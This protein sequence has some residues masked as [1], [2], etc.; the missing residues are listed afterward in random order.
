[1][2][3]FRLNNKVLLLGLICFLLAFMVTAQMRT[4]KVSA[5]DI[6]RLKKENEL[7]DEV[8]RMQEKYDKISK[9]LNS[10]EKYLAKI[11]ENSSKDD[12]TSSEMEKQITLNNNLLGMT[13]LEGQGV[14]ITVRDASISNIG[15]FEDIS[16]YIIHDADL[17]AIVNDLKNAGAEA[18][19][20]NGQRIVN[21][22]AITCIGNVIKVN[23]EKITSPFT[24]KAIG[25]QES[26]SGIDMAGSYIYYMREKGITVNIRKMNKVEI[27]KYT[28]A[29][30]AK[31]MNTEN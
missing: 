27:P 30:S 10:A 23:D 1:M 11:R 24:I 6:S 7:R 16:D 20:I 22:T 14:E 31:Y 13:N 21:T 4:I 26:L 29:I 9:E 19:S 2:M 18:I 8:L 12:S 5:T 25:F 3:K 28:G 17:R 15:V